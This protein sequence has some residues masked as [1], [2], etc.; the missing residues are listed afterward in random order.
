MSELEGLHAIGYCRVS[1]DDKGQD[2]EIQAREIQE[3]AKAKGV[4]MDRIYLEE[5]SGGQWPRDELS[6]ALVQIRTSDATMLVC[7]DQSRLTRDADAH[8]PYIKELMGK[9]KV[10]RYVVNGDMDPENVAT[11]IVNSIK[12]EIAKEERRV[13]KEKTSIALQYRRDVLHQHVGR[14]SRFVITDD[15]NKLPKGEVI[16]STIV[17]TPDKVLSFARQGWSGYY[18]SKKILG[19]PPMTWG[20]ALKRAGLT[21]EYNNILQGVT[22]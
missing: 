3:W 22:E 5:A 10:I 12:N 9:G 2:P 14:P 13:T 20:R 6:K 16:D 15:I 18:V 8:L 21:E 4:L 1:T 11:K 7:Y 19:I 17:L